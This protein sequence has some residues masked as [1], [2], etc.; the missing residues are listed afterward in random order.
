MLQH[1]HAQ[2]YMPGAIR[3]IF[4]SRPAKYH[5]PKHRT[6]LWQETGISA[7]HHG[8]ND[9]D[10]LVVYQQKQFLAGIPCLPGGGIA[11]A[12]LVGDEYSCAFGC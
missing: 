7:C 5:A 4:T 6:G 11:F 10:K 9:A 3:R 12:R 8:G 1:G 2:K